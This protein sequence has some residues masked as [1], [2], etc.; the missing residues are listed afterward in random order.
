MEKNRKKN[1]EGI[2]KTRKYEKAK[3]EKEKRRRERGEKKGKAIRIRKKTSGR[4]SH[5]TRHLHP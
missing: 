5:S 2:T 4:Q 1:G 3:E